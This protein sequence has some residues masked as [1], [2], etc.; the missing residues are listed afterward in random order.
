M[1][2][3][4]TRVKSTRQYL[5]N[6]IDDLTI[7]QLNKTHQ[8][9]NNNIVWNVAH[10][11][12]VQQ[13]IC[14]KRAGLQPIVQEKY[15]SPY[16]PNTK[17]EQFVDSSELEILKSLLLSSLDEFESD[18]KKSFFTNY[19]PFT[20]RYGV[21][22]NNIDDALNFVLYHEGYHTGIITALKRLV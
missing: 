19:K 1:I 6:L 22:I 5:L 7:E 21:E 2:Q 12:A 16:L 14:Y 9:F 10:L 18:Y 11:T 17:P 20:T 3:Q 13:A 15:L 4:I 8:G